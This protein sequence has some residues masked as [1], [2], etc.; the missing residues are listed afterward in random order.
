MA[1][2]L[3]QGEAEFGH[4]MA[5]QMSAELWDMASTAPRPQFFHC[6]V[7]AITN[8]ADY[9]HCLLQSVAALHPFPHPI[10]RLL[11]HLFNELS[12]PKDTGIGQHR[13]LPFACCLDLSPATQ[14][15]DEA[16]PNQLGAATQRDAFRQ[17]L[18]VGPNGLLG[19]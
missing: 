16:T 15:A 9:L 2:C 19:F 8:S 4:Q 1:G 12:G 5:G 6:D 13:L 10:I 3:C 11:K 17:V 14:R 7:T 18:P